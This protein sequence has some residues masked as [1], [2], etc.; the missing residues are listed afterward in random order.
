MDGR[1]IRKSKRTVEGSVASREN[2]NPRLDM[3]SNYLLVEL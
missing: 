2:I 3:Q 1:R